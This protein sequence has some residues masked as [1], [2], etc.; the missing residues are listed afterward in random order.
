MTAKKRVRRVAVA[1]MH[2]A[3]W[4]V[5]V[6][7]LAWIALA[8]VRIE[9]SMLA[10]GFTLGYVVALAMSFASVEYELPPTEREPGVPPS[11][12]YAGS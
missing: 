6:G 2:W 10:L 8:F 11:G 3:R 5:A 12:G 1:K 9:Y 4:P 7:M